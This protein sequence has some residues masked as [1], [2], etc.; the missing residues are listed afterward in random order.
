MNIKTKEFNV[1][2][3]E[4]RHIT[5]IA[6]YKQ[7]RIVIIISAIITAI[8]VVQAAFVPQS[9]N[10]I[11][12]MQFVALLSSF[13]AIPFLRNTSKVPPKLNFQNRTCEINADYFS[14]TYEDG[15][16]SKVHF[17]NFIK[18]HREFSWYFLYLT[19]N[20]FEYLPLRVFNS[21]D[22]INAFETLIKN[23][24]LMA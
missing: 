18:V 11:L 21:E 8:V 12:A 2:K 16:L 13:L 14:M 19:R 4:F 5:R 20:G 22:N 15:S 17:N 6:Y 7:M 23:K 1:S 10:I 3:A 24:K 9:A